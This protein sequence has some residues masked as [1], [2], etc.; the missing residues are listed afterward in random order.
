MHDLEPYAEMVLLVSLTIL[1]GV[2]S[3]R[4]AEWFRV[5][6]PAPLGRGPGPAR[7]LVPGPRPRAVPGPRGGRAGHRPGAGRLRRH[8]R[9]ADRH[10]RSRG[11]P[12]RRRDA[13]RVA[14]DAAGRRWR[15]VARGG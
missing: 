4:L 9:P 14:P 2:G 10:R 7:R 5:P 6:A 11:D 8:P 1:L 13:H 3:S 15:A 12:V